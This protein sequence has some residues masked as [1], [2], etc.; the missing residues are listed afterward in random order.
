MT[1][2]FQYF[3]LLALAFGTAIGLFNALKA[4]KLI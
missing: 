1:I 4:I 2:F 3:I